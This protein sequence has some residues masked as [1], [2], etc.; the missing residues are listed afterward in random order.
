VKFGY[1]LSTV[2]TDHRGDALRYYALAQEYGIVIMDEWIEEL[3]K[4]YG[5]KL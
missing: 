3:E 2:L 1:K 4:T 5:I